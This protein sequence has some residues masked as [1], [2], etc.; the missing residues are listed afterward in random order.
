MSDVGFRFH[1]SDSP[2]GWN[3]PNLSPTGATRQHFVPQ[4]F[5]K[6]FT[7]TD[8]RLRVLDLE[9]NTEFRTSLG[10]AAVERGF[11]DVVVDGA[12]LSTEAWLSELE[13]A[14]SPILEDLI[15]DPDHIISLSVEEEM[16][17]ARFIAAL[18]L[19]T[20]GYRADNEAMMAS[21][22]TQT[23]DIIKSGIFHQYEEQEAQALWDDYDNQPA[24][25]WLGRTEQPQPAETSTHMLGEVQ[26]WANLLWGAPWRIGKV[27]AQSRRLYISD[28][29][30]AAYLRPVR[31]WWET[32][33][34]SSLT[35]KP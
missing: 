4:M 33:A 19:R 22:V 7:G 27:P 3:E 8:G 10:N 17:L 35:M 2:P 24:Y 13:G 20:P 28:N 15:N 6:S 14:A 31:P 21:F 23:K 34:F 32:A 29:P 26:G 25:K 9:S 1:E 12:I 30:V 16:G 18:R 11:N 5:L